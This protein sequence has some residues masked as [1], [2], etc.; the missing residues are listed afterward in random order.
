MKH[1]ENDTNAAALANHKFLSAIADENKRARYEKVLEAAPTLRDAKR[2]R[3]SARRLF[4]RRW[5]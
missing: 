5:G 4:R 2:I 1:H 3:R